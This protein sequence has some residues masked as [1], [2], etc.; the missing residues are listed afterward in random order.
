MIK[1]I[2]EEPLQEQSSSNKDTSKKDEQNKKDINTENI[3]YSMSSDINKLSI[4]S[5]ESKS[6]IKEN[7]SLNKEESSK[8]EKKENNLQDNKN[9][10]EFKKNFLKKNLTLSSLLSNDINKNNSQFKTPLRQDSAP[11]NYKQKSKVNFQ[12]KSSVGTASGN[13]FKNHRNSISMRSPIYS[14]FDESQKFLSEQYSEENLFNLTGHKNK[15]NVSSNKDIPKKIENSVNSDGKIF[16]QPQ[17]KKSNSTINKDGKEEHEI[18][19]PNYND[20]NFFQDSNMSPDY[21]NMSQMSGGLNNLYGNKFSR[22]L[23]QATGSYKEGNSAIKLGNYGTFGDNENNDFNLPLNENINN[24]SNENYFNNE[25]NFNQPQ[26]LNNRQYSDNGNL[27]IGNFGNP[28]INNNIY[29]NALNYNDYINNQISNNEMNN[30]NSQNIMN[31]NNNYLNKINQLKNLNL[32][33]NNLSNINNRTNI[34]NNLNNIGNI[35]ATKNLGNVNNSN[36]LN[37]LANNLNN[38]KNIN[39]FG[40]IN[41]NNNN[42]LNDIKNKLLILK[43]QNQ[44]L[45]NSNFQNIPIQYNLQRNIQIPNIE[46]SIQN[47]RNY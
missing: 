33:N 20:Y 9:G 26:F 24:N 40:N 46:N 22:K 43:A 23:S 21:Y 12:E 17:T 37:N 4:K 7:I 16:L 5:E 3:I 19:T 31:L 6:P 32:L 30:N 34:A 39:I 28:N 10:N 14:Y 2:Q 18:E 36:D 44:L 29:R 47:I 11:F 27:L 42:D 25:H 45:N 41:N 8:I 15:K 1:E 38:F 35:I 13:E